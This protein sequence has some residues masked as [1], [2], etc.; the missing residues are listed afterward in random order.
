MSWRAA[1][2]GALVVLSIV[3]AVTRLWGDWPNFFA[4][5]GAQ[6]YFIFAGIHPYLFNKTIL[7]FPIGGADIKFNPDR[8]DI[9][10][11]FLRRF[12]V[13]C[14]TSLYIFLFWAS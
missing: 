9:E 2:V 4:V 10:T 5:L 13:F 12:L 11:L 3:N 7:A 8:A 14:Y 1:V 6:A